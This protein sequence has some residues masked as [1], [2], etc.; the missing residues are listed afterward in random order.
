MT[1]LVSSDQVSERSLLFKATCFTSI[2]KRLVESKYRGAALRITNRTFFQFD[3]MLS[4]TSMEIQPIQNI[5][6]KIMPYL[7]LFTIKIVSN[8]ALGIISYIRMA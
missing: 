3:S 1:L 7:V 5:D 2:T 6:C 8:V 4:S